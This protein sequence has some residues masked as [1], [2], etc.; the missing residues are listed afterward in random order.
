M[1]ALEPY[2]TVQ[3]RLAGQKQ[4]AFVGRKRMAAILN[5]SPNTFDRQRKTGEVPPPHYV[6]ESGRIKGWLPSETVAYV[7]REQTRRR[8]TAA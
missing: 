7:L 1:S 4:E 3:E 8:N 6:S 5:M 2:L